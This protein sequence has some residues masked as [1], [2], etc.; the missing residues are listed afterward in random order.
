MS[1]H[2]QHFQRLHEW[3]RVASH[4]QC[5]NN[6]PGESF[7]AF[8]ALTL[9]IMGKI[10][11]KLTFPFI[12]YSC[13]RSPLPPPSPTP[14]APSIQTSW[15]PL[16]GKV[17]AAI[18]KIMAMIIIFPKI[19]IVNDN[20]DNCNC[21]SQ[22]FCS[23]PGENQTEEQRL[24]RPWSPGWLLFWV[25]YWLDIIRWTGSSFGIWMRQSS[26]STPF[27]LA[28]LQQSKNNLYQDDNHKWWWQWWWW[29]WWWLQQKEA[30]L[31]MPPWAHSCCREW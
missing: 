21:W 18:L 6:I 14:L 17:S 23:I 1:N 11:W 16:V 26:Y 24:P 7:L 5:S 20:Q 30:E 12:L 15:S 27:S 4:Q 13:L 2:F 25:W 28:P 9:N 10:S 29:W 19:R 3:L 22:R 8:G 31:D